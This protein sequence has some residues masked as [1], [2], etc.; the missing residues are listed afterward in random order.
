VNNPR[1]EQ[2]ICEDLGL[3]LR[4]D[5]VED[6]VMNT[7]VRRDLVTRSTRIV[8]DRDDVIWQHLIECYERIEKL[9]KR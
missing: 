5:T 7:D 3:L 1:I 6:P 2:K 4:S 8:C 9:E